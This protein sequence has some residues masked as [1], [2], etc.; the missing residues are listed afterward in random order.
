MGR[1]NK[2][3]EE[4]KEKHVCSLPEQ[5]DI[6]VTFISEGWFVPLRRKI[7][8]FF[9]IDE[10]SKYTKIC[11]KSSF[12]IDREKSYHLKHHYYMIHPFSKAK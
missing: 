6:L 7:K 3:L 9:M 4:E 11:F 10:N 1:N 2:K 12:L 8:Q 5:E